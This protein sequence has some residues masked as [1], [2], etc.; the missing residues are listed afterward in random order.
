M[1]R[2]RQ[3][4]HARTPPG[5]TDGLLRGGVRRILSLRQI[6]RTDV[7]ERKRDG[8]M[9]NKNPAVD[10]SGASCPVPITDYKNVL[11][12]HGGG[13]KLTQQLIQRM[14][15]SQFRSPE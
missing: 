9:E 10:F 7:S 6:C 8:P 5:G 4:M 14:F 15:L 11:L 13:G 2:L 1:L 12:A 3:G